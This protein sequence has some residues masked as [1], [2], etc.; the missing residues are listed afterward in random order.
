MPMV[1]NTSS[2]PSV[3][4][5]ASPITTLRELSLASAAPASL[6]AAARIGV[7]DQ[8]GDAP[9]PVRQLAKSL[10]VDA[11]V[12]GRVLRNLRCYG[13][14][15]ATEDGIVHTATSRLLREDHPQRLKYWVLWVTEP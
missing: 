4:E 8:L 13:I 12:L 6:R 9:V 11:A 2:A 10:D 1:R 14:F 7:A 5:D 15:D 3:N